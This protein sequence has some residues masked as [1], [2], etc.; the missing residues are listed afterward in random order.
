MSILAFLW[1]YGE[2]TLFVL[3]PDILISAVVV[4]F[5]WRRGLICALLAACGASLGA[6]TMCLW[7]AYEPDIARSTI[8]ALPAVSTAMI[9]R[10]EQA[11][12]RD[13]YLAMLSGSFSGVPFKIYAVAAGA[14]HRPPFP[15]VLF[16]FFARLPR[17]F[18][19][20]LLT[21]MLGKVAARWLSVRSC[22][23]LLA[24][25]WLAFYA[26]YFSIMTG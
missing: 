2:A 20:V 15:F 24:G 26:G 23:W 3:V 4:R 7:A 21:A 17:F 16:S 5:G 18:A 10:V 6:L 14:Q 1:G 22:L 11:L 12:I 13:G 19:V 25:F 8:A 9:E